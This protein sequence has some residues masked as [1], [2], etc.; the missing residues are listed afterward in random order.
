MLKKL[1]KYLLY[2]IDI[3][4]ITALLLSFLAQYT[5]PSISII[6]SLLGMAFPYIILTFILFSFL[7]LFFKQFKLFIIHLI[8]ILLNWNAILLQIQVMP[9]KEETIQA[10]DFKLMSYNVKVFDLYNWKNKDRNKDS[11]INFIKRSQPNIISFQEFYHDN[12]LFKLKEL[13]KR[14]NMPYYYI[15]ETNSPTPNNHFGIAIMSQYRI[16]N[17]QKINLPNTSNAAFYCDILT[18]QKDTIRIFN[19]HLESYHFSYQDYKTV[20]KPQVKKEKIDLYK[21]VFQRLKTAL[22]KRSYQAEKISSMIN[23]SPYPVILTGDFNDTPHS[24][25]YHQISHHLKDAFVETGYGMSHTYEGDFPSFRID[26]ILYSNDLES[27]NY[28]KY[29]VNLSDHY[30][31]SCYFRIKNKNHLKDNNK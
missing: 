23:A 6:I 14:L 25:T 12:K 16:I 7:L 5:P 28:Q 31:I 8:I 26:Y 27:Y 21:P 3:I 22:I 13:S 17:S 20:R 24:Y 29:E 18:P 9:S 10:N 1:P 30:P 11:I 15:E 4:L 19:C 2:F